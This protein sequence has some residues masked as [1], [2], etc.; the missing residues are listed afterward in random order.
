[1]KIKSLLPTRHRKYNMPVLQLLGSVT[2]AL[3]LPQVNAVEVTKDI[4]INAGV[5]HESNPDLVKSNK[6]PVWIYSIV[7]QFQLG[8]TSEAN[9][10]YLDA[11]L[12][13]QRHSNE[14]VLVDRED[15]K[16]AIGWDRTYESGM[17]GIR[18]DYLESSAREEELK[19]T[20]E[21]TR[22]DNTE[23]IK[24]LSAKWLHII[25]PRWSVLTDGAYSDVAFSL[26][27]SLQGYNLGDIRSKLTYAYTEKLDTSV[28]LGY[29]QLRPEKVFDDTEMVR[30]LLDAVY[31]VNER[32]KCGARGGVY[33]LTGRQ[34]D[35]DWQA[36]IKAEY[37]LDR[38]GYVAELN[39]ELVASGVGGFQ[40]VDSLKVGWAYKMSDFDQ[41]GAEYSLY[42]TK[43]DREVGL[44]R[45][46]YQQLGAFYER[47][48]SSSWKTRL[49][50]A[51]KE[52]DVP[53]ARSH[54]NV[55]GVSLTYDTLSF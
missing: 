34:S 53:D 38:T 15:P 41:L 9:R 20:G 2:L 6:E 21:F 29:A 5:V 50:A 43:K 40:K 48:L 36:G 25:D 49:S 12:L 4:I 52:Q 1:M 37:T 23:K 27:G 8:I 45:L 30:L 14:R 33:N 19:R 22:T 47:Q 26:P 39:R 28:E 31:Q 42:K 32:F 17:F 46:D 13:V 16:L 51:Y 55:I 44:D 3:F 7:P 18:A 11:A 35:T 10:W 24:K 54:G